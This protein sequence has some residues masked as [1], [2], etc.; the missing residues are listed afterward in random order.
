VSFIG[1]GSGLGLSIAQSFVQVQGGRF[2]LSIDG[3]LFKASL[4]LS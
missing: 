2:S 3:D 4:F 1:E